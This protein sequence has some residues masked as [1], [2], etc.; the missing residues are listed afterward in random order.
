MPEPSDNYKRLQK[1][2]Y[3]KQNNQKYHEGYCAL[4]ESAGVNVSPME[5]PVC[6][7]CKTKY[8]GDEYILAT[9]ELRP[10]GFCFY[11]GHW[12]RFIHQINLATLNMYVCEKCHRKFTKY[13]ENIAKDGK[14]LDPR[15]RKIR[16]KFGKDYN[17]ILQT[18]L[19]EEEMRK[20]TI[21][22]NKMLGI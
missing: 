19:T 9:R 11:K 7:V 1:S 20:A 22:K 21:I 13:C 6:N 5:M 17:E 8:I 3:T 12:T 4:C 10:K 2:E 14:M 16:R 18:E 15:W